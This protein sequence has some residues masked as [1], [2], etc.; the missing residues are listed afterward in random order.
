[1]IIEMMMCKKI[2]V[3]S[4]LANIPLTLRTKIYP[5]ILDKCDFSILVLVLI[6]HIT[7][8]FGFL[9]IPVLFISIIFASMIRIIFS[10]NQRVGILGAC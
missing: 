4:N 5:K 3:A 10:V 7:R 8:N 9:I 6:S 1:M 2:G